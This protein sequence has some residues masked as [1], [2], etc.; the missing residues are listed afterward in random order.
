[1]ANR[2]RHNSPSGGRFACRSA[3]WT[4]AATS[5]RSACNGFSRA[6]SDFAIGSSSTKNCISVCSEAPGIVPN[7]V[8]PSNRNRNTGAASFTVHRPK[9]AGTRRDEKG[10]SLS[11]ESCGGECGRERPLDRLE[12]S[13]PSVRLLA[14]LHSE[15]PARMRSAH[16]DHVRTLSLS[17]AVLAEALDDQSGFGTLP[18]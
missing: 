10:Q 4:A 12:T 9:P 18:T 7:T 6:P 5:T 15:V 8:L 11:C 13:V 2:R 17:P 16:C 3:I 1:M 14:R